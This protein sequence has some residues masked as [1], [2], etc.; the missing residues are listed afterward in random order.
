MLKGDK[1]NTQQ[2]YWIKD[3]KPNE[4]FII[5]FLDSHPEKEGRPMGV[6]H[7]SPERFTPGIKEDDEG[8]RESVECRCLAVW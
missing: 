1:A 3:Q 2:W 4:V 8:P 6:H 7:G 5:Q